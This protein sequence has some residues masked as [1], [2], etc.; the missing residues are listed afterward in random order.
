M[1]FKDLF[2]DTNV[3]NEKNVVGFAS[4]TIMILFAIVDVVAGFLGIEL[5]IKEFIYN[6]FAFITL[7]CF[8]IDGL[9]KIFRRERNL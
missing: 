8:G 6:S 9:T 1:A 3:I 7:G 4:F 5:G 2:N